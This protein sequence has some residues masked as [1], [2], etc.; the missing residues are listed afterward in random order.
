MEGPT[1]VVGFHRKIGTWDGEIT[2][3]STQVSNSRPRKAILGYLF[4]ATV[5]H[6]WVERNNH[7]FNKKAQDYK[8]IVREIVLQLHIVGQKDY[9]F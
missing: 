6:I 5:Y 9:T 3:L 1:T 8:M 4:A 7:R 2:W